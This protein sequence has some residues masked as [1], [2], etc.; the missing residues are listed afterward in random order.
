MQNISYRPKVPHLKELGTRGTP[1]AAI[2]L[3]AFLGGAL[4]FFSN[5]FDELSSLSVVTIMLTYIFICFSAYKLFRDKKVRLLAGIGA[6]IT[7]AILV[8]YLVV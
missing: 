8:I 3:S 5:H 2:V 1:V 7:F 4:L 6:L